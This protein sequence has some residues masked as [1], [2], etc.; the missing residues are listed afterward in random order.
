M[1]I[2]PADEYVRGLCARVH[3][4]RAVEHPYLEALESGRLPDVRAALRDFAHQYLAHS[5]N[6]PRY[7]TAV[8]SQLED[9]RHRTSLLRNL[10]EETG[11][12]DPEAVDTLRSLAIDP[13]WVEHV[14]HPLL[15]RRFLNALG[16]DDAWLAAHPFSDDAVAFSE[17]YL[18]CFRVDR[19]AIAIGALGLGT[20]TIVS[21]VYTP[22]LRAIRRHLMLEPRDHVF[23]DL[24]CAVDDDHGETLLQI[25][26]D[27]AGMGE[28]ERRDL[29]L[30]ALM[31]LNLRASF[32]DVMLDRARRMPALTL[33]HAP[34]MEVRHEEA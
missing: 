18:R 6:F 23:F 4:H 34:S 26:V 7:L 5:Q 11:S 14:P 2:P 22:I 21:R 9:P 24:H 12:L 32:F 33:R 8:L 1:T 30:G 13:A 27:F 15:Y 31:A 10:A 28:V 20:E 16:M 25:A 19:P 17:L 29:W 3:A